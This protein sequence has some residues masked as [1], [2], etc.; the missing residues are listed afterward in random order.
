MRA[1]NTDDFVS[2]THR[3][4]LEL[5]P[6][7]SQA[8][9]ETTTYSCFLDPF[10]PGWAVLLL[11]LTTRLP[12]HIHSFSSLTE[13]QNLV[14]IYRCLVLWP[15][16]KK[17]LRRNTKGIIQWEI[18]HRLTQLMWVKII[19]MCLSC[20]SRARE[21]PDHCVRRE[22]PLQTLPWGK[23]GF[24]GLRWSYGKNSWASS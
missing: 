7:V 16:N 24:H 8:F 5:L 10:N 17:K 15:L 22:I 6:S 2:V 18:K 9:T 21:S 4:K 13:D 12:V 19:S 11:H 3:H 1:D 14:F 23:S 20:L